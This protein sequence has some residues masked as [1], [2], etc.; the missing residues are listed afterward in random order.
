MSIN[1][2]IKI[3]LLGLLRWVKK[4]GTKEF[5]EEPSDQE[6]IINI[7]RLVLNRSFHL[8]IQ[9]IRDKYQIPLEFSK[10][11][12][13]RLPENI[14]DMQ[15]SWIHQKENIGAP[16]DGDDPRIL[17][18]CHKFH[19]DP[20]PYPDFSYNGLLHDYLYFG[21]NAFPVLELLA[22][23]TL[24]EYKY[25]VRIVA[26]PAKLTPG[27]IYLQLF[28][29][30]KREDIKKFLDKYWKK[31]KKGGKYDG[32][33]GYLLSDTFEF[34]YQTVSKPTTFK[35]DLEMFLLFKIS[36]FTKKIDKINYVRDQI[37]RN[38][39]SND[40]K[41]IPAEDIEKKYSL[42]NEDVRIIIWRI[43]ARLKK[44]SS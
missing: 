8:E 33:I 6:V 38:Y 7:V 37:E 2:A 44:P 14:F 10:P 32:P 43:N 13:G 39:L 35:R 11:V 24:F 1:K 15:A 19:L 25:K 12:S 31:D 42:S 27:G 18:L 30:S 5:W 28:S 34:P 41:Q 23:D 9:K 36:G 21:S 26:T 20:L 22:T 17:H 40:D 4:T 29:N 3:D 16:T